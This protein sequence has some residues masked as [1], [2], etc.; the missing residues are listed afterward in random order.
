MQRSDAVIS[1]GG[2]KGIHRLLAPIAGAA[3]SCPSSSLKINQSNQVNIDI[4]YAH[5]KEKGTETEDV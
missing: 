1:A 4:A 3:E 2:L 5:T